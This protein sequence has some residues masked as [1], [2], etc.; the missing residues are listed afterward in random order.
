M[1]VAVAVAVAVAIDTVNS[2]AHFHNASK[3]RS[4]ILATTHLK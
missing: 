1:A 2:K 3:L 4:K